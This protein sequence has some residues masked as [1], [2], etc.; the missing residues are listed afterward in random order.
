VAVHRQLD[1]LVVAQDGYRRRREQLLARMDA[2]LVDGD[3]AVT[4]AAAAAGPSAP[5]TPASMSMLL[6]P[7]AS[8]SMR[9]RGLTRGGSGTPAARSRSNSRITTQDGEDGF[10]VVSVRGSRVRTRV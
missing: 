10:E 5:H 6:S 7:S 1:W 2:L 9:P 4:G 8:G 3:A